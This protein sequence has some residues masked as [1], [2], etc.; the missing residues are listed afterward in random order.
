MPERFVNP[1]S[2]FLCTSIHM[3]TLHLMTAPDIMIS[4]EGHERSQTLPAVVIRASQPSG[5]RI[6]DLLLVF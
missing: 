1:I 3:K 6:I 2:R 5:V 4:P